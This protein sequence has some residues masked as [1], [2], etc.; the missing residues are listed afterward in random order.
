MPTATGTAWRAYELA[1]LLHN[2]LRKFAAGRGTRSRTSSRAICRSATWQSTMAMAR[3]GT[4]AASGE[5]QSSPKRLCEG[6][7]GNDGEVDRPLTF[8]L[9]QQAL[10]QNQLEITNSFQESLQGFNHRVAA[11]E[12]SIEG[13]VNQT[14]RLLQAMAESTPLPKSTRTTRTS[15]KG[16]SCLK[17]SSPPQALQRGPVRKH[18]KAGEKATAPPSSLGAM[19]R[20]KLQ[21]TP[22]A[23]KP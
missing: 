22:Y 9:L 23:C 10:H 7:D 21:K 16:L 6:G 8:A 17:A 11:V 4:A 19:T 13:H 18:R 5:P 20:T 14:T 12:A 1:N 15:S 3:E 2:L